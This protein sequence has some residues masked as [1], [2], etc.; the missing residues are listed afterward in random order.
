MCEQSR[1][2]GVSTTDLLE[3]LLQLDGRFLALT[4]ESLDKALLE[5]DYDSDVFHY[6]ARACEL[7]LI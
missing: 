1:D 6:D 4:I 2:G 3:A 7:H 5:D